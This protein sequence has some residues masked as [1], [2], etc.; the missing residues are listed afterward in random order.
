MTVIDFSRLEDPE[1]YRT[2]QRPRRSTRGRATRP[3]GTLPVIDPQ[4]VHRFKAVHAERAAISAGVAQSVEHGAA[5]PGVAGSTPAA[6]SSR[7]PWGAV[8]AWGAAFAGV[9]IA[10]R[11]V[12]H[13]RAWRDGL[14]T[15]GLFLLGLAIALGIGA[16]CG[17]SVTRRLR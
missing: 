1:Y 4:P 3:S 2:R 16:A 10:G 7:H 15:T 13:I 12:D 6:R 14:S 8:V 5:K 9:A 17:W 11:Y